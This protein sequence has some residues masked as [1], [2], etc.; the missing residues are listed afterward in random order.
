M[1]CRKAEKAASRSPPTA[2]STGG[3]AELLDRAPRGLSGLPEGREGLPDDVR[4]CCADGRAAE[5]R[6]GFWARLE[7]RLREEREIVP[8]LFWERLSLR[9]IPVFLVLV[10]LIG[11][12][13]FFDPQARETSA[14]A[15][16]LLDG[17]DPLSD[18]H[19]L[20]DADKPEAKSMRLM[21][22]SLDDKTPLRRPRP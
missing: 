4:A 1:N 19:A 10:A 22:A 20:F 12:V 5:P 17:Q 9:A 18:V 16:L 2:G 8:L 6:R 7:P 3:T 15:A 21:F 14:S 13:L 11:G